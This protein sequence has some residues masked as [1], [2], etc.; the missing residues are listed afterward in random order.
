VSKRTTDLRRSQ[1]FTERLPIPLTYDEVHERSEELA[2]TH[3]EIVKLQ[4]ERLEALRS[5]RDR[6]GKLGSRLA[7]LAE[8]VRSKQ[9]SRPVDCADE[10]DLQRRTVSTLRLD[11]MEV[12]RTRVMTD[13][14]L[15]QLQEE[16]FEAEEARADA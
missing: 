15:E 2:R 12:V 4:S 10:Y 14:D 16:L 5:F 9:E 1:P 3:Q 6:L 7:D 13:D 8:T 11:T